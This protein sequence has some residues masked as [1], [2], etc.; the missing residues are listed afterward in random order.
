M[1]RSPGPRIIKR[2][3]LREEIR[4]QLIHAIVNGDFRPGAR[5][6]ETHI[7]QEYGVSQ[8][9]V[10]EALR[11]LEMLGFVVSSAFRGTEVRRVS[12]EELA[13][14]YPIRAALEGVAARAAATRIDQAALARLEELLDVMRKAA[15]RRDLHAE[16]EADIAFHHTIVEAS[17]SRLL[18]QFWE[19][20]RLETSTFLTVS[21]TR[22]PLHELAERHAPILAAL[23]AGDPEAAESAMRRHIEEAGEWVRAVS[24][25]AAAEPAILEANRNGA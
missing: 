24:K 19:S 2:R 12:N 21:I 20:M 22:R 15:A 5:I 16:V 9:P 7:A 8:A 1:A 23:R 11:D 3:V 25:N 10:R 6:K 14:I 4:E 13:E 17:G 18:N